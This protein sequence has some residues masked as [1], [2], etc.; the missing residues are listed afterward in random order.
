MIKE[1]PSFKTDFTKKEQAEKWLAAQKEKAKVMAERR[2][3]QEETRIWRKLEE[4]EWSGDKELLDTIKH[5]NP[6][7]YAEPTAR[8]IKAEFEDGCPFSDI[9]DRSAGDRTFQRC[10]HSAVKAYSKVGYEASALSVASLLK[11]DKK[12][13]H[14]C[15][16]FLHK[17]AKE[18]PEEMDNE[19]F[20]R[21]NSYKYYGCIR[22]V[23]RPEIENI[24]KALYDLKTEGRVDQT[25][26]TKNPIYTYEWPGI[27]RA[28]QPTGVTRAYYKTEDYDE[29]YEQQ[30]QAKALEPMFGK[31]AGKLEEIGK[32]EEEKKE[33]SEKERERIEESLREQARKMGPYRESRFDPELW[34]KEDRGARMREWR[35][36]Q[37]SR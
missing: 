27:W 16:D 21:S 32:E 19:K 4:R 8:L 6:T 12:V 23:L 13:E 9:S 25:W 10:V 11:V 34:K 36:Q 1:D 31:H 3:L 18:K 26:G 28:G 17:S 5:V 20:L 22:R 30:S 33:L 7:G 2:K 24:K 15:G 14:D 35:A 29:F 37:K